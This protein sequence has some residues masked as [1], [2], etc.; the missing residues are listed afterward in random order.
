MLSVRHLS[1]LPCSR[2][3]LVLRQF[4]APF[5]QFCPIENVEIASQIFEDLVKSLTSQLSSFWEQ[6]ENGEFD[7]EKEELL[8]Y[9]RNGKTMVPNYFN[10][11]IQLIL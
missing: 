11:R 4:Y 9:Y 1:S 2:Q 7:T 8:C 5:V 3:R 10:P 6:I